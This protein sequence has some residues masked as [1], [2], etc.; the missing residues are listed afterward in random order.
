[1]AVF[2]IA[3]TRLELIEVNRARTVPIESLENLLELL[4]IV[5]VRLDSN[6]HESNLLDLL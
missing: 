4:H 2:T 6:G 5:G 1:M 3:K